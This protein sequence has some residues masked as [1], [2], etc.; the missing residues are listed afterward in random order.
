M[1]GSPIASRQD[2]RRWIL[3]GA[4][5]ALVT[6]V[7]VYPSLPPGVRNWDNMVKLQV[8]A[9]ILRG[10]GA[11]LTAPTPDDQQYVL[12]GVDGR[13]YT[14]YP[15]GAYILQVPTLLLARRGVVCEGIGP[16][17]LL[18]LLALALVDWGRRSE[19]SYA[20]A[21]AGA[22]L[23]CTGT[24]FWPMA[25]HGYDNVVEA[26]A[27]V[28][29]FRAYSGGGGAGAWFVAGVGTAFAIDVRYGAAV[30]VVPAVVLVGAEFAA[31]G[32]RSA[33]RGACALGAGALPGLI[34]DLWW[35]WKR[36]GSPLTFLA[37]RAGEMQLSVETF[38]RYHWEGMA[39]LLFSPGKGF[40]WYAPPMIAVIAL[41]RVLWR[42]VPNAKG[43][44]VAAGAYLVAATFLFGRLTFWHGEWGWGPRYLSAVYVM[45]A[46]LAWWVCDQ[47][48][49][50]RAV[51][52]LAGSIALFVAIAIQMAAVVGYPVEC[53]LSVVHKLAESNQ[54]VTRPIARPPLP[55]DN[56]V[57]YFEPANAMP[58]SLIRCMAEDLANPEW[59]GLLL[60]GLAWASIVPVLSLMYVVVVAIASRRAS[61]LRAADKG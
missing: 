44:F 22:A 55:E 36:F 15:L 56:R 29:L 24:A 17:V 59:R 21:V 37:G 34:I 13:S 27:L 45:A 11:V 49:S 7:A 12:R 31:R 18:A 38:S 23:V 48:A 5:T 3:I 6:I 40:V 25:A 57:L 61:T 10:A 4:L 26:L 53:Q 33:I 28:L 43:E 39:G 20:G 41:L 60:G 54:T 32:W 9:N 51:W 58:V 16:L 47:L 46:P 52:K 19:A 30:L 14:G 42:R 8:A 1:N 50:R 2:L 35:N